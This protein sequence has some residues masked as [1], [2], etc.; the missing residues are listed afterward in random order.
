[1]AVTF[2]VRTMI[3]GYEWAWS[4]IASW[5]KIFGVKIY[6]WSSVQP[7]KSRIS[8]P[9]KIAHYIVYILNGTDALIKPVGIY[10]YAS[11][12]LGCVNQY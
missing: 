2:D 11:L 8:C 5:L 7:Q 10:A 4:I 1:M 6:S 3:R 12:A 9:P